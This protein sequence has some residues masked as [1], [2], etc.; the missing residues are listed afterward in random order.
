METGSSFW[1]PPPASTFAGDVDDLYFFI[2]WL[3]VFFFLVIAGG[4]VLFAWKYRRR[5]PDQLASQ[6][7]THNTLIEAAWTIIPT[8]IVIGIFAWSFKVYMTLQVAPANA[9]E[10]KVVGKQ[11]AWEFTEPDGCQ[12]YGELHVEADKPVKLLM[13]SEDVI[14]SFYVPDFRIKQDVIPGR[15]TSLW[16]QAPKPNAAGHQVFCTEYCGTSHSDMLA[17]IK[18][19]TPEEMQK[20]EWCQVKADAATGEKLFKALC[21]ACHTIDGNRLVGPSMKGL[22]GKEEKLVGGATVKVDENYIVESIRVPTA[23]VV[24]TYPP[25]MPPFPQL[26]DA[27]IDAIIMYI[28]TLK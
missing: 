20:R 25:A 3:N 16:F 7:M 6:Q 9:P 23:K 15:Y 21:A 14:H 4:T 22:F 27:E 19:H 1:M 2:Y 5:H 28:K 10:Y 13:R 26:K 24:D 12:T 11:W 18:V 17:K 8:I